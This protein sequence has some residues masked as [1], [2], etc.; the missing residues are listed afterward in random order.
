[1]IHTLTHGGLTE[2]SLRARKEMAGEEEMVEDTG[3][4]APEARPQSEE[5]DEEVPCDL[6]ARIAPLV[7]EHLW[8]GKDP[9]PG[10]PGGRPITMNRE[11]SVAAQLAERYSPDELAGAIES[12]R[13][14]L[15]IPPGK[16]LSLLLFNGAA[17]QQRFHLAVA[18][19]RSKATD[20]AAPDLPA[21]HLNGP[22]VR[23]AS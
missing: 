12:T 18:H 23:I 11:L 20:D 22:G 17:E 19:W 5:P 8:L 9:P 15:G 10:K 14:A 6:N 3:A 1:M 4:K 7:R 2:D 21:L 13:E 16:R